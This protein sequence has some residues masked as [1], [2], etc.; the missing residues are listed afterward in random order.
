MPN[1]V[2]KQLLKFNHKSPKQPQYAPH[3]WSLLSYGQKIQEV[4]EDQS[5]P[6]DKP[7]IKK[8]QSIAGT[9]LYYGRAV[10]PTI[11]PALTDIAAAQSA[12]TEHTEKACDMLMDYLDTYPN[13]VLQFSKSD[14]I[15]YVDS[16]AAYLVLPKAR[17]RIAGHFYLGN[18]PSPAPTTP[19]PE[20]TN[21]PI[22][23]ACKR[24]R[25]VVSSAAEAE[26][27][28]IFY[29]SQ[30]A[31]P[32]RRILDVLGHKQPVSGTPFKTDNSTA[33]GF[34]RSNIKLKCS[35]AWDMQYHWI[36]DKATQRLFRYYWQKGALNNADYFTKHHPPNHHVKMRQKYILKGNMLKQKLCHIC[37]KH[38]PKNIIEQSEI[39]DGEGVLVRPPLRGP[40]IR[41]STNDTNLT[42]TSDDVS[43]SQK[44][45][46][47]IIRDGMGYHSSH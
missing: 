13:A 30:Y 34:I 29:N 17:S 12:P 20:S 31:I 19:N 1:Y 25:N 44:H 27:G 33:I 28:G 5:T 40:V 2:R 43:I 38:F 39:I 6:L 41:E 3:R 11:L 46:R 10:D 15:L 42:S 32:I 36:R 24:L 7:N 21:A 16:D 23:T 14:M 47:K 45:W 26:T 37:S 8:V 18:Q 4:M 22:H 9:F 35:K